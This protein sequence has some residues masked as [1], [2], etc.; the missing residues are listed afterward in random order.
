MIDFSGYTKATIEIDMLG[1]VDPNLDTR[2]GSMIQTAIAP[3]A[4]ALEGLYI[5]LSQVQQNAFAQT[6]VGQY[7]DYITAGRGIFRKPATAAVRQGTFL[8]DN[9]DP[10]TI[11]IGSRFKTINGADSVVFA[12]GNI[13]SAGVYELTCE[14][15]GII[16]N[17]YTGA[18]LPITAIA[19]LASAS[20]GTI[21]TAGTDEETDDSLRARYFDSFEAVAFAGNIAAYRTEILKIAGVGGVQVYPA[22]SYNGGGTVLC[23]IVDDNLEPALQAKIDEVQAI[24]CPPVNAPASEG[25]GMAPIGAAVDIVTATSLSID[26]ECTIQWGAGHGGA[27]DIQAVED[28]IAD[29]IATA[30]ATWGE[31]LV[32]YVVAYNVT[33]YLARVIAAILSV[34]GVENVTGVTINGSAADL[35]L[36]ETSALQEIPIIGTVTIN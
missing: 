2:E 33:I 13:I 22:S 17:A 9:G 1:E 34:D 10:V 7:L 19:G 18:I 36:T 20:I 21:I 6:A 26:I 28:A 30:A 35:S 11:P 24:I 23:S 14:T 16:G 8:D 25:F 27:G 31:A 32:T 4:W 29:Y 12:S 5:I 15:A 3:G